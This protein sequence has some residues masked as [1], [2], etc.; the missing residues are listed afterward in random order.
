MRLMAV[1]VFDGELNNNSIKYDRN[2]SNRVVDVHKVFETEHGFEY[3][4]HFSSLVF[5]F[6]I[7]F[8]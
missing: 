3:T 2:D 4:L 8:E 7:H 6:F 5:S 1:Y